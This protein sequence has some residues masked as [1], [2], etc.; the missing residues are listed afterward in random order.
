MKITCK[1]STSLFPSMEQKICN[2]WNNISKK[3][4]FLEFLIVENH[5]FKAQKNKIIIKTL[6][7]KYLIN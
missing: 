7:Q 3:H 6:K 4:K 5:C 1:L 2:L